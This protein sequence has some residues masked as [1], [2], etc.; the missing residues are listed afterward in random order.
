MNKARPLNLLFRL[1]FYLSLQPLTQSSVFLTLNYLNKDYS[2]IAVL[3]AS[4]EW[5]YKLYS[6]CLLCFLALRNYNLVIDD[7]QKIQTHI[8]V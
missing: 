6:E 3:K 5:E 1:V 4:K 8:G 7:N 2:L